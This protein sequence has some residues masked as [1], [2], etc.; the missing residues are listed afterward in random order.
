MA[1]D[2]K[3]TYVI[4]LKDMMSKSLKRL[5]ATVSTVSMKLKTGLVKSFA[6]ATK[7]AKIGAAAFAA[8]SAAMAAASVKAGKSFIEAAAAAEEIASRF[9]I[10]FGEQ[11]EAAEDA[12]QRMSEALGRNVDQMRGNMADMASLFESTGMGDVALE[13]SEAMTRLSVDLASFQDV[14]DEQAFNAIRSGLLGEAEAL[15]KLNIFLTEAKVKQEA[16]NMGLT[17]GTGEL[18]DRA[19]TMAR[20]SIILQSNT[21]AHG[22]LIRTQDSFN[23]QTKALKSQVEGL[24]VEMGQQL[25]G[26]L[27]ASAQSFGGLTAI[28]D[29]AEVGFKM[30]GEVFKQIII[31][32]M[33]NVITSIL[34]FIEAAGGQRAAL[35][36]VV[37]M[38]AQFANWL[39]VLW[40]TGKYVF[41]NLVVGFETIVFAVEAVWSILKILGGFLAMGFLEILYQVTQGFSFMLKGMDSIV[42]FIKDIFIQSLE[43]LADTLAG[44]VEGFGEVL[45]F[46]SQAPGMGWLKDMAN[47]AKE[48][49]RDIRNLGAGLENLKGG[50]TIA[51]D[52]ALMLERFGAEV[53]DVQADVAGFI[54]QTWEG[55][56]D[57]T[58]DYVDSVM[59]RIPSIRELEQAIVAGATSGAEAFAELRA[60][61]NQALEGM[62]MVEIGSPEEQ[63]AAERTTEHLNALQAALDAAAASQANLNKEMGEG[64]T[65]LAGMDAG[66][67]SFQKK[68][69]DWDQAMAD[70]T[71]G[72]LNALGG[73]LTSAFMSIADG[74]KSA[75]EAFK[76]FAKQFILQ[77][78]QMIIQTLV[79][80]AIKASLGFPMAKGGTVI[81]GLGELTAL[82]NG[83]V[84]GGG[85]GRM[86][87][88]KGY[89][90]GGPI[91]SGPHV[92]L[93]GE[94]KHNEAVV[95][96]PDG[97]SIPVDLGGGPATSVSINIDAVDGPSVDRLLF[98]RRRTLQDII[99][100]AIGESRSFRGSVAGAR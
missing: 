8:A 90:T 44:L 89:A 52:M 65:A 83:G 67:E 42:I 1:A 100:Q 91:V 26:A 31:P 34:K 38:V 76:D 54:E 78:A 36:M 99:S 56:K 30:L 5:G 29:I 59:E 3:V 57:T 82:A 27:M 22:D 98:E 2:G 7:A 80:K 60:Q 43:F 75:S 85:L 61:V 10:A 51:Q 97:K 77:I 33:T 18:D 14:S 66:V 28:T 96:L 87:P 50:E 11:A 94:G 69:P 21:L 68:I 74:S 23:N 12:A 63:D 39:E 93:V 58:G 88:V 16:L 41:H 48:A 40:N 64:G 13:A 9:K 71:E 24:R 84:V 47:S 32:A 86:M 15:K 72:S 20:L 62:A 92:A 73:G 45:E 79:F 49:A 81:G 53:K 46:I 37:E 6:A 25:I 17:D 70:I 55:L 19:K 4:R 95:P 35:E